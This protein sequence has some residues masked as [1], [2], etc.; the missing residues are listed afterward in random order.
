MRADDARALQ[1]VQ[2][3]S[4]KTAGSGIRESYPKNHAM[5]TG[6]LG[7]FLD[8][9]RYAVWPTSRADG[10]SQAA[11]VA[12]VVWRGAFW[13][14]SVAGARVRNLRARPWHRFQ[15]PVAGVQPDSHRSIAEASRRGV[16]HCL[17]VGHRRV[18]SPRTYRLKR[19]PD[20]GFRDP[21]CCADLCAYLIQQ[22][23]TAL[24]LH[25]GTLCAAPSPVLPLQVRSLPKGHAVS[26]A[27]TGPV[28][29]RSG[30]P[31]GYPQPMSV[32]PSSME[33]QLSLRRAAQRD[34]SLRELRRP[35]ARVARARG[36]HL[37]FEPPPQCR[38]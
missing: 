33:S 30:P 4:Y 11:P 15:H 2:E 7:E 27:L 37:Q 36:L 12:F 18:M 23:S 28:S 5:D 10:R 31:P 19:A 24:R 34:G 14:A 3:R 13:V 20:A 9:K 6:R 16:D 32:P 26:G 22:Y 38:V 29:V 25:F 8:S 35:A 17:W 1:A 21:L